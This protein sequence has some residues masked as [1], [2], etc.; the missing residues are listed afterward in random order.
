MTPVPEEF[1]PYVLVNCLEVKDGAFA[2]AEP[3]AAYLQAQRE[4]THVA[5]SEDV[6]IPDQ[7]DEMN[8][9]QALALA[10][11]RGRSPNLLEAN[12]AGGNYRHELAA[13]CDGNRQAANVLLAL[14]RDTSHALS[15]QECLGIKERL[16]AMLAIAQARGATSTEHSM[17]RPE[18]LN[19]LIRIGNHSSQ[20][21]IDAGVAAYIDLLQPAAIVACVDH[22]GQMGPAYD[23]RA[24]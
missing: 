9:Y 19:T 10:L 17:A 20:Y 5:I 14:A 1:Q 15:K 12:I 13:L 3:L 23:A 16:P 24:K 2:A 6:A 21:G 7:A 22:A 4:L 11:T 8:A 18:L